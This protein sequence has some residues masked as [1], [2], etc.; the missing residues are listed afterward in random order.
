MPAVIVRDVD[1]T[2]VLEDIIQCLEGHYG[3]ALSATRFH[4]TTKGTRIPLPLLRLTTDSE[5]VCATLLKE[6]IHLGG[7]HCLVELP[8][9]AEDSAPARGKVS[10]L[11]ESELNEI[12]QTLSLNAFLH[13]DD[14]ATVAV[15]VGRAAYVWPARAG[16]FYR[17]THCTAFSELE[18]HMNA[19]PVLSRKEGSVPSPHAPLLIVCSETEEYHRAARAECMDGDI[20]LEIGSDLGVCCDLVAKA[21]GAR[22]VVGIDLAPLSVSRAK[23]SYPDL[24]FEV[25]DALQVGASQRLHELEDGAGGRFT[26]VLIDINGNR[27][28]EALALVIKMVLSDLHPEAVIVKNRAFFNKIAGTRKEKL[29]NEIAHC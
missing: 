3:V 12:L 20:V 5:S 4:R 8:L 10:R 13:P 7:K 9:S 15:S 17:G 14:L 22:K 1:T 28:V 24:H 29:A 23:E 2:L 18:K 21:C 25:L 27:D 16:R 26:K 6:G 19:W 11:L